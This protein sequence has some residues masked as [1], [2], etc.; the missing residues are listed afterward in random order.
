MI[1][2]EISPQAVVHDSGAIVA[3]TGRT[4]FVYA[5]T[6]RTLPLSVE[7]LEVYYVRLPD[8]PSWDD[9]TP[10][11]QDEMQQVLSDVADTFVHW[12][13]RCEFVYP[14]DPRVLRTLDQL[15]TYVRAEAN[16]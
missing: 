11:T 9:G 16:Q 8:A 2:D 3:S 14:N 7:P 15:V 10:L 12:H 6:G 4:S 13:E 1:V 5:H